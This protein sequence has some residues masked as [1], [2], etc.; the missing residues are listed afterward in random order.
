MPGKKHAKPIRK[1]RQE[2]SHK[3]TTFCLR[4]FWSQNYKQTQIHR[5]SNLIE[6]NTTKTTH[7]NHSQLKLFLIATSTAEITAKSRNRQKGQLSYIING[8]ENWS[9]ICLLKCAAGLATP[10]QL[11]RIRVTYRLLL[12]FGQASFI[13]PKNR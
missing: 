11:T 6:K 10:T 1:R 7:S 3:R 4:S 8:F 5:W 13:F 2:N 12:L 9:W